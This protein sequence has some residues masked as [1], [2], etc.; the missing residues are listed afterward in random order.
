MIVYA[1]F[2]LRGT[3]RRS[4]SSAMAHNLPVSADDSNDPLPRMRVFQIASALIPDSFEDAK[5]LCAEPITE[6]IAG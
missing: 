4:L 2:W 3:D 5:L 1:P 6:P